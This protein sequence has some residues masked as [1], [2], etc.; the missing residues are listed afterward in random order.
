MLS[1]SLW[2]L[3][4]SLAAVTNF[5]HIWP[6]RDCGGSSL[7]RHDLSKKPE[8]ASGILCPCNSWHSAK[9]TCKNSA[10]SLKVRDQ[11]GSNLRLRAPQRTEDQATVTALL[12]HALKR[13]SSTLNA[14]K[15][16][17]LNIESKVLQQSYVDR[18]IGIHLDTDVYPR[19]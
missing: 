14:S 12:D 5:V 18:T 16:T 8:V 10:E 2:F 19:E 11:T 13:T 15:L 1:C 4:E 7:D 17:T 3:Y 6:T 9:S